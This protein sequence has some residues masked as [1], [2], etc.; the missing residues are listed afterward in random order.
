MNPAQSGEIIQIY[1]ILQRNGWKCTKVQLANV[2]WKFNSTT[3]TILDF[4]SLSM[5]LISNSLQKENFCD[6]QFK[7]EIGLRHVLSKVKLNIS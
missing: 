4:F 5:A 1:A 2:N 7:L 6:F 3:V